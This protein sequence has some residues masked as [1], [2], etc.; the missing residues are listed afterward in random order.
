MRARCQLNHGD[1]LANEKDSRRKIPGAPSVALISRLAK[2]VSREWLCAFFRLLSRFETFR[3]E[4]RLLLGQFDV[5]GWLPYLAADSVGYV[6]NGASK[7]KKSF[8]LRRP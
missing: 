8:C 5:P 4:W 2:T 6:L 1:G 3:F 7:L